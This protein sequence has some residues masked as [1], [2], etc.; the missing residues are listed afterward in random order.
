MYVRV[1]DREDDRRGLQRTALSGPGTSQPFPLRPCCLFGPLALI[2]ST[3]LGT[4]QGSNERNGI[5]YSGAAGFIDLGHLR[6]YCDAAYWAY[7]QIRA[8]KGFP[9]TIGTPDGGATVTRSIPVSLWTAVARDIA[10]D[11][12]LGHEIFTYWIAG[13]GAGNSAFSPED[14]CSNHLGTHVAE[15]AINSLAASP[16][17]SYQAAV[18][19]VLDRTLQTLKAQ[20]LAE[21]RKAWGRIANCWMGESMWS[22]LRRRNFGIAPW[23]VGH[24][25]D[26]ATPAWLLQ[27]PGAGAGYYAYQCSYPTKSGT[28]TTSTFAAQIQKIR[29]DAQRRYGP[30]YDQPSCP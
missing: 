15:V 28:I 3:G 7:D 12:G 24:P 8:L 1:R 23:K 21:T 5:F 22:H 11:D 6:T 19:V 29:A 26:V 13:P 18:T 10:F 25:S 2:E 4:H 17:V 9:G 27:P 14:L 16:G 20:P 30:K